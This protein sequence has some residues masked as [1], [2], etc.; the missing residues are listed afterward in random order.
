M[1]K[2]RGGGIVDIVYWIIKIIIYI[3]L[4]F[5]FLLLLTVLTLFI[6]GCFGVFHFTKFMLR[7]INILT[8]GFNSIF[9]PM[10][11]GIIGLL[12]KV[13]M[14]AKAVKLK[15]PKVPEDPIEILLNAMGVPQEE[16]EKKRDDDDED[17]ED[18]DF[19]FENDYM[20]D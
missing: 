1:K 14:K 15:I 12:K 5:C 20:D 16:K 10:V 3:L 7:I 4:G 8:S 18:E 2:L 19:D 17:D 9:P 13:G 11:K 6:L